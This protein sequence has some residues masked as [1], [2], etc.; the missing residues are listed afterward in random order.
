VFGRTELYPGADVASSP[1]TPIPT[2]WWLRPDSSA[3]LVGA[4]SEVVWNRV[5]LS[6]FSA[7][8]SKAGVFAGPPKVCDAPNP[9][10]SS[11]TTSTFGAPSGGRSGLIGGNDV[12]GS[13][14]SYVVR[15]TVFRSGIGSTSRCTCSPIWTPFACPDGK[16]R[17]SLL[18]SERFRLVS[19]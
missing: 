17:L 15:F 7:N 16:Q 13:F 9:T 10:S 8:L 6:P 19:A 2:V 12:S 4:H 14:A 18:V 1:I 5:Y 11:N 3:A